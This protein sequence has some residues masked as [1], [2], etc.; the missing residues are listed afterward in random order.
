MSFIA[1]LHIHANPE[2][3]ALVSYFVRG[4]G[5]RLQLNAA[6]LTEAE[7]SIVKAVKHI[8]KHAE[9]G[10]G[11]GGIVLR[12]ELAKQDKQ[13]MLR[14]IIVDV[15]Q[16][17]STSTLMLA[18]KVTRTKNFTLKQFPLTDATIT[19]ELEAIY[20][21]SE[22]MTTNIDL[23]DLLK[24]IIDKLVDT[25]G[26]ERGTMYLIDEN[27]EELYSKI[28][29]E[30][31]NILSEVRVKL[32]QGIAGHVGATGDVIN[33]K[34]VYQDARWDS[35]YDATTGY[36]T[37]TML[38]VPMRN[39]QQK[40]IGV[41]QLINKVD[42]IFS[43]RDERMLVSMASQAAISIENARLYANEIE[44]RLMEQELETAKN[45]QRSFLP[46][47]VEGDGI[48]DYA[49]YW[50]PAHNVAGDFYDVYTLPD[51][52]KAFIIADVA[53][54]GVPA[55]LFMAL[56]VTVLRFGMNLDFSPVE[57]L[58]H[59]NRT[60][61]SFNQQSRAFASV[62][63]AYL[64]QETGELCYAS[65]GHNPPLLYRADTHGCEFVRARGMLIG[66]MDQVVLNEE[67]L[68]LNPGDVMVLYT[69]GITE[70]MTPDDEEFGEQRLANLI[71]ENVHLTSAEIERKIIGEIAKWSGS[72]GAFDDETLLVIKRNA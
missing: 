9:R 19:Q 57:L 71:T 63:V 44:Q 37:K 66:I 8:M 24:L 15:E 52:R 61:L 14:V 51:G 35:S 6:T 11:E 50:E 69:D 3:L 62:F 38:A 54:K 26:A 12:L 29:L 21:I 1:E 49:A 13:E 4:V 32:G 67:A 25:I 17:S 59:A 28:L 46:A 20:A 53:G 36:I 43:S 47:K 64:N 22:V 2:D 58:Q 72:R 34:D 39:A 70:A 16:D 65:G 56:C 23:T 48:W 55:A 42:G 5:S 10:D 41:V 33:L 18:R 45:I 7:A 31:A 60:I 27:T 30:D 68:I 40:I